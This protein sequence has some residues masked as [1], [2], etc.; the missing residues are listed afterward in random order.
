MRVAG[1]FLESILKNFESSGGVSGVAVARADLSNPEVPS[2]TKLGSRVDS[3]EPTTLASLTDSKPMP[4]NSAALSAKDLLGI[5]LGAIDFLMHSREITAP[6]RSLLRKAV[7]DMSPEGVDW[8]SAVRLDMEVLSRPD[9]HES[10]VSVA[11]AYAA[12][13]KDPF[14]LPK[15]QQVIASSPQQLR[16]VVPNPQRVLEEQKD[17]RERLA[18]IRSR[19]Q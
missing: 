2:A 6:Q 15:L 10:V 12:A 16:D 5:H 4:K 8:Q 19:L 3:A 18:Q 17:L 11:Q 7:I 14:A 9:W 13:L 1:R